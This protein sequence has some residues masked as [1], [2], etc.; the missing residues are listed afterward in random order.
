MIYS[1]KMYH[2]ASEQ[3]KKPVVILNLIETSFYIQPLFLGKMK[4]SLVQNSRKF[5]NF[6]NLRMLIKKI[7]AANANLENH[8]FYVM[9]EAAVNCVIIVALFLDK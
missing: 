1:N 2:E 8:K 4:S 3:K 5:R 7:I 6:E 9:M